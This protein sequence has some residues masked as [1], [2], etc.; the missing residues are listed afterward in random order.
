MTVMTLRPADLVADLV[1]ELL[2]GLADAPEAP[3]FGNRE[4]VGDV[5]ALRGDLVACKVVLR[6][7]AADAGPAL[8]RRVDDVEEVGDLRREVVDVGIP[9]AVV[10]GREEHPRVVVEE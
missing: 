7:G 2:D 8:P 5:P 9:V 6:L 3:G 1:Q 10:R 4:V